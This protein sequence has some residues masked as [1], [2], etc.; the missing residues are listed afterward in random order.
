MNSSDNA[1]PDDQIV[2][3]IPPRC[4]TELASAM[5]THGPT[6][7]EAMLRLGIRAIQLAREGA[8]HPDTAELRHTYETRLAQKDQERGV[9]ETIFKEQ[10][11]K[12]SDDQLRRLQADNA[13]WEA[14]W[15]TREDQW[16]QQQ[17]D[18]Q[19]KWLAEERAHLQAMETHKSKVLEQEI[20]HMQ[21][22]S[23]AKQQWEATTT[24]LQTELHDAQ[25]ALETLK[26]DH[27]THSLEAQQ[28]QFDE[29][30]Q[31]LVVNQKSSAGLGKAGEQYFRELAEQTFMTYDDFELEDKTKVGH[32]GDF[33]LKFKH[34]TVLVDTKN[35]EVGRISTTDVGKFR[36]DMAHNSSIR[37]GWLISLNGSIAN[38]SRRPFVC[39]VAD[40]QLMVV[41]NNLLHADQPGKMLEELHYVSSFIYEQLMTLE[42]D[43]QALANYKRYEKKVKECVERSTK[44]CKK[45]LASAKQT[46]DDLTETLKATQD[47]MNEHVLDVRHEHASTLE[48]WWAEALQPVENGKL[49]SNVLYDR[50]VQDKGPTSITMDMFK[51]MLRTLLPPDKLQLPKTEKSQYT[52]VGFGFK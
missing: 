38:Y 25:R 40:G 51:C 29:I 23:L 6:E 12:T 8:F 21:Q 4:K 13:A 17:R 44:L 7:N 20:H 15:K 1:Q 46:V 33:H 31:S 49:K 32:A 43:S 3:R 34:F 30:K 26:V 2:V 37:V 47:I 11:T 9:W 14:R 10:Y 39:E 35:F 16:T 22:L 50:F 27:L 19:A 18:D 42:N 41:V 45:A 24:R 36:R 28:K 48:Q 5:A 52:V